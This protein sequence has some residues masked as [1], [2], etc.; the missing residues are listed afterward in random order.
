ME[1]MEK[2]VQNT[3]IS[4]IALI[5]G[6]VMG[7]FF[8]SYVLVIVIVSVMM[9]FDIITGF[10]KGKINGEASSKVGYTGVC[11]KLMLLVA[12]FFGISFDVLVPLLLQAGMQVDLPFNLPFG[13]MVGLQIAVN[14]AVSVAENL[15]ESGVK[16]PRWVLNMLKI[17][18]TYLDGDDNR[19]NNDIV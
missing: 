1:N 18:D 12:L 19:T 13:V 14:E 9:T 3:E 4:K 15:Y 2:I 7:A 16:L 8:R 17:A 10:L 6:G 5:V 11:K